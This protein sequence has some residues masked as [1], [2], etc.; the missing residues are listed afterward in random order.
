MALHLAGQWLARFSSEKMALSGRPVH[1]AAAVPQSF[2]RQSL[3]PQ[4]EFTPPDRLPSGGVAAGQQ[5][6]PVLVAKK[7]SDVLTTLDDVLSSWR[8]LRPDLGASTY[9]EVTLAVGDFRKTVRN[10]P[11]DLEH[12]DIAASRDKLI[13][14]GLCRATVSKQI[15]FISTLLR[16]AYDAGMQ[17][18]PRVRVNILMYVKTPAVAG[19]RLLRCCFGDSASVV[20]SDR[21]E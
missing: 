3:A 11:S 20:G 19:D 18:E 16:T 5:Y 4:P 6:G 9:R 10:R 1:R 12:L 2:V 13:G 8:R 7:E 21:Q 15:S 14:A 17:R